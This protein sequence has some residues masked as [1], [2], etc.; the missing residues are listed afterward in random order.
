MESKNLYEEKSANQLKQ[1]LLARG[2]DFTNPWIWLNCNNFKSA[3]SGDM[4]EHTSLE[5]GGGCPVV[6]GAKLAEK[7]LADFYYKGKLYEYDFLKVL[8]S[9]KQEVDCR[10]NDNI[11][12][13]NI[14]VSNRTSKIE[15]SFVCNKESMNKIN[16]ENP[17]VEKS[18]SDL[19]NGQHAKG[20][21][22]LYEKRDSR[23]VLIDEL[24]GKNGGCEFGHY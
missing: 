19:W 24:Y 18:H 12:I 5:L 6:F 1:K 15:V 23:Y 8:D 3:I 22:K 21:V 4:M 9:S 16:Y 7:V 20:I 2:K 11:I 17:R 13:W 10:E 14:N